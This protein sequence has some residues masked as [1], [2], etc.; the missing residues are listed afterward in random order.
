MN[1]EQ[2][3]DKPVRNPGHKTFLN[4]PT[5]LSKVTEQNPDWFFRVSSVVVGTDG[6]TGY[7]VMGIA[8]GARQNE[9]QE[10]KPERRKKHA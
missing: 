6:R 5:I 7:V 10:R 2:E 4:C 8:F 1:H 3:I 9:N